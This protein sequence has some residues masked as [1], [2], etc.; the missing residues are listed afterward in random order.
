[1][2][3][4][5]RVGFFANYL[6]SDEGTFEPDLEC[7]GEVVERQP[8]QVEDDVTIRQSEHIPLLNSWIE[9]GCIEFSAE[10]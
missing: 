9:M 3:L 4:E 2:V 1:M 10:V 8:I 7:S 5:P 6:Y